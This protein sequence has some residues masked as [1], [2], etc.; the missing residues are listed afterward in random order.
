MQD[1][2]ELLR[3][4]TPQDFGIGVLFE[5]VADGV[6]V[7]DAE[8]ERIVLFNP[9][10]EHILG[11]EASELVGR[12]IHTLVPERLRAAHREGIGRYAESGDGKFIGTRAVIDLSALRRDG[13]EVEI[14]LTLTPIFTPAV[15]GRFVLAI[16]R[17]IS[18]RRRLERELRDRESRLEA[19]LERVTAQ[20]EIRKDLVGMVVHDLRSPT[21][22]VIGFVDL[23]VSRWNEF[24]EAQIA[25]ML[26]RIRSNTAVLGN[27]IDDLLTV[28]HIEGGDI[29]Y[30][31]RPFDLGGLVR[32]VA[33]DHRATAADRS[34]EV[35]VAEHLP[36]AL[37]DKQRHVRI[38]ANLISNAIRYSPAGSTVTIEARPV[39]RDLLV[40]VADEGPGLSPRDQARVFERFGRL[41]R[42]KDIKGTG[43]GLYIVRRFVEDQGGRIWIDSTPGEGATFSYT[44]PTA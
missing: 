11:Y 6:L 35:E 40:S 23:L 30:E 1:R 27:L 28:A 22:I 17:D 41:D 26:A 2:A 4:L 3:R 9:A 38:L 24:D 37:G 25:D 18:G 8:T 7:G 29:D 14:A 5:S 10:A 39:A 15:E 43:L 32:D 13:T 31:I 20:E 21:S 33:A 44:V 19:A 42:H 16:L 34:V 36:L 12:P